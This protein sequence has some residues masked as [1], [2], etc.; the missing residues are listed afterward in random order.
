MSNEEKRVNTFVIDAESPKIMEFE[1]GKEIQ[2]AWVIDIEETAQFS[3]HG[4]IVVKNAKGQRIHFRKG[5]Q[6]QYGS[7]KFTELV[8]LSLEE[9][10]SLNIEES[11]N[12]QF[13][14]INIEESTEPQQPQH[15]VDMSDPESVKE[16]KRILEEQLKKLGVN[17]EN[18]SEIEQLKRERDDLAEKLDLI[19]QTAFEKKRKE[20]GAPAEIDTPEKLIGF[21]KAKESKRSA[22]GGTAPFVGGNYQGQEGFDSY[23]SMIDHLRDVASHSNPDLASREQAQL[24]LN[25]LMKKAFKGQKEANKAFNYQG[26][27]TL[28]MLKKKFERRKKFRGKS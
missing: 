28:D 7:E 2:S 21:A 8:P 15:K 16:G 25:E 18:T 4:L 22:S 17:S 13:F 14:N 27:N 24:V 12:E 11:Q 10:K 6:V 19:A 3:E 9:L 23:N 5:K 26:E 20:L 1:D